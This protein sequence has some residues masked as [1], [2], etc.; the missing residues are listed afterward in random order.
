MNRN[1]SSAADDEALRVAIRAE[2]AA[3]FAGRFPEGVTLD[4]ADR[5]VTVRGCVDDIEVAQR[6]EKA[7]AVSAGVLGVH[8]ELSLRR[9]PAPEPKGQPQHSGMNA[10]P[11]RKPSGQVHHKV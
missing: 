11:A 6:I 4:V 1:A 2:I 3:A 7:A 5:R 9:Q 8:N 10:D